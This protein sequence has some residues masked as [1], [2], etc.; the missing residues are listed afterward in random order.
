MRCVKM[1]FKEMPHEENH[2]LRLLTALE[3]PD[4]FLPLYPRR[5]ISKRNTLKTGQSSEKFLTM[6]DAAIISW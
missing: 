3:A 5:Q 6:T 1:N 2:L 4:M